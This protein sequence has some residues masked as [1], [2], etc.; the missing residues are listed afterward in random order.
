[1]YNFLVLEGID[2]SG[3]STVAHLLNNESDI[4]AF[5]SPPALFSPIKQSILESAAPLARLTYFLA[6][7]MQIS[8]DIKDLVK[9]KHVVCVRYIFSTIAYHAALENIGVEDVMPIIRGYIKQL[10]LPNIVAFLDVSREAQ[11]SRLK[12]RIDDSLQSKLTAS[13]DFQMRLRKA[14]IDTQNAFNIPWENINTELSSKQE[15]ID[16][17]KSLIQN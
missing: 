15:I 8:E 2:G 12:D 1:M 5:E 13:E 17:I 4:Y 9:Q 10:I 3:K 14:Y 6:G 11:L 7:N 16:K